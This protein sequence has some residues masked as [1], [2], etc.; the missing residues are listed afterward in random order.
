MKIYIQGVIVAQGILKITRNSR[1]KTS[2]PHSHR[3]L[4]KSYIKHYLEI[5]IFWEV[6]NF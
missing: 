5:S 2:N 1:I 3:Y 6:I 4:H